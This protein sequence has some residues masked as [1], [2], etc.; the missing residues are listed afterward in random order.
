MIFWD[1]TQCNPAYKYQSFEK[2]I[3]PSLRVPHFLYPVEIG[4]VYLQNVGTCPSNY[5]AS[6]PRICKQN[7]NLKIPYP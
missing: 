1:V 6:I 2:P 3:A 4:R 7:N 5:M